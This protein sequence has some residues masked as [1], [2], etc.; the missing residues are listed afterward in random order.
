MEFTKA[1]NF[2]KKYKTVIFLPIICFLLFLASFYYEF[3][4][5]AT[6]FSIILLLLSDFADIIYYMLF[7]QM[8]T[9]C[10]KFA[11]ISTFV[12]SGLIIL[13]YIIGLAKK[14]VKFYPMPFI[15]TCLICLFFSSYLTKFDIHGLYQGSSLIVSLF[16]I[17]LIFVYRDKLKLTKCADFLICGILASAS[18]S[19]LTLLFRNSSFDIFDGIGSLRRLKLL[20][21]NENSL[22]I[23]C[24]LA[25]S[26]YV[27]KIVN[28]KGNLIKNILFALVAVVF[29]LS[30]LSKC[31][32]VI[33]A[34]IIF[35]LF[36]MLI[37][38]YKLKSIYFIAPAIILIAIIS[39]IFRKK[40]DVTF[41][42]F[43]IEIG[44][45]F[46]L[47]NL[48]TGRSD[49]WTLY[50]N[51][52]TSS[53]PMMLFGT[54]FFNERLVIIG[55]HNL[56]IHLLYRMGFIGLIALGVLAYFY[57]RDSD[58]SLKLN[59]KNCLPVLVFFMISMIESFL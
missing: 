20:T 52:I 54:G 28:G 26:F 18:I 30:T 36:F 46:S 37:L 14:T 8:F 21:D 53:I 12:A 11:I 19:F 41:D 58:K 38:K 25:L 45:K 47:S 9:T 49:L 7:F 5:V 32:L 29:G 4:I 55:P 24:S 2:V 6:V 31:F 44:T 1:F 35:Y 22:S 16:S 48:T 56:L 33:C 23:Y 17:Y 13:N 34:F 27:S 40:I 50:I 51:K 39:F 42:R 10:G 57:Y 3:W 59:L 15:L 43:L